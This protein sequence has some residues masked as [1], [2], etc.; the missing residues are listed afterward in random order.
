MVMLLLIDWFLKKQWKHAFVNKTIE[1]FRSAEISF[2][3]KCRIK[4]MNTNRE[5]LLNCLEV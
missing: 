1:S 3:Y 5:D 2:I 4:G